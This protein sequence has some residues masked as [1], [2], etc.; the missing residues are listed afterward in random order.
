[1]LAME[2]IRHYLI[3]PAETYTREAG[4]GSVFFSQFDRPRHFRDSLVAG[5]FERFDHDHHFESVAGQTLMKD[6]FDY[7]SPFGIL[8]RI[9]DFVFLRR[10][11][12]R[13]LR[14]RN[15]LIKCVAESGKERWIGDICN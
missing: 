5:A 14:T 7:T 3:V 2:R 4:N 12:S 8:G 15:D 9:A 6:T 13:L 1:M 10:Y 11:M